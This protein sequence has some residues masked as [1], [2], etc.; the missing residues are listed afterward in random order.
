MFRTELLLY[1][2]RRITIEFPNTMKFPFFLSFFLVLLF[3]PRPSDGQ[4][5]I[6]YDS[7]FFKS[8]IQYLDSLVEPSIPSEALGGLLLFE[9]VFLVGMY[10]LQSTSSGGDGLPIL[11]IAASPYM[12]GL[13]ISLGGKISSHERTLYTSGAVLGSYAGFLITGVV[14]A[15]MNSNYNGGALVTALIHLGTLAGGLLGYAYSRSSRPNRIGPQ[16]SSNGI[17]FE[18]YPTSRDGGV[19]LMGCLHF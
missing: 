2:G 9:P 12:M 13:G 18:V 6:R 17:N 11:L 7:T 5:T 14:F 8:Q 15:G 3:S 4:T 1:V 16:S 10:S 19:G